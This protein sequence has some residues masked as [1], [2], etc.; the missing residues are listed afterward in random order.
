MAL[1]YSFYVVSAFHCLSSVVLCFP[2]QE[3][4]QALVNVGPTYSP[5]LTYMT[6]LLYFFLPTVYHDSCV[7]VSGQMSKIVYLVCI[8]YVVY[9]CM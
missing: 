8:K 5:S 3:S 7:S 2:H 1:Y 4:C 9:I 6:V